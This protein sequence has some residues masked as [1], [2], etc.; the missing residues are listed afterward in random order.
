MDRIQKSL[1]RLRA[2]ER[3]FVKNILERLEAGDVTGLDLQKLSGSKDVYR[4]RKGDLRIIF[5]R[6][7][8]IIFV[9]AIERRS[10][11]TYRKF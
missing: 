1:K 5:L 2:K 11:K 3:E 10:E 7:E 6:K 4:V 8:K 9:L